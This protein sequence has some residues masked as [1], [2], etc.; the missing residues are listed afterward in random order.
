M[1]VPMSK[2]Q[3]L[4]PRWLL[5]D[6]LRFLHAQGVLQLRSLSD[7]LGEGARMGEK[8]AVRQIPLAGAD[9]ATER[10]LEEISRRLH[11]LLVALPVPRAG[12][13][14]DSL[15]D[16]TS[17]EFLSRLEALELDVRAL[18]DRRLALEEERDLV[19]RYERLLTALVPLP[20]VLEGVEHVETVGILVRRDRPEVL[21]F[22][23]QE[24]GR[25]TRGAYYLL[26]REV[27]REQVGVLLTVPRE[28]ARELSHLLFE[29][30]ITEIKLPGQYAGQP[31]VKILSLLLRRGQELP[32]EIQQLDAELLSFSRQWHGP[33]GRAL[34]AAQDRL[35]RLRAMAR[36]GETEHAFV[37]AGWVPAERCG[38]LAAALEQAFQGRVTL[39]EHAIREGEYAEVPVVLRN[40]GLIRPFELLLSLVPLPRYG[41][42]DP[43]PFLAGFFP[44]FFGLMLGDVGF[45][46]LTLALALVV[47]AKRW[48]GETGRALTTIALACAVSA[49]VFGLLF[50][51]LFG[52]LGGFVGL[53]PILL[54]RREAALS[55]LGLALFLGAIH[56]L[57]GITLALWTA[58]RRAKGREALAKSSTLALILAALA[59]LLARLGYLP[60]PLEKGALLALAP[61][62]VLSIVLEGF[63]APLELVITLGNILSYARLMALG[64]ASVMLAQVANRLAEVFTPAV[65]G[66]TAAVLLHGVN[67]TL[68]L[69]G[70]TIQALRLHY[71]EFFDKFYEA[72]GKPYE[73]FRLTA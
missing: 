37:I 53:R 66:V 22:L 58:L 28:F 23:E 2:A 25:I 56:I 48:G 50:G 12:V 29:R 6:A 39:V 36:C 24:V 70:P 17:P 8:G 57:L 10:S 59:W 26:S 9:V 1:I 5:P 35:A 38:R 4:G 67:F 16:V 51:E 42:T 18:N 11:E 45:G 7:A 73:P 60:P 43:T 49:I 19:A 31:L 27:D 41:S 54:H 52:E 68:G 14:E 47:R 55:F 61:L 44:L 64:L 13:Q 69:L 65:L 30:G 34:G 32:G 21:T 63:L 33:L 72:G 15:P 71:V 40:P 3:V 46:G 62:L 20:P